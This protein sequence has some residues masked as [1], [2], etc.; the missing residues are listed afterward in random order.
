MNLPRKI[1]LLLL[2]LP[3]SVPVMFCFYFSVRQQIVRHQMLEAME[4]KE[5]QMIVVASDKVEW[6]EKGKELVIEGELFD[7]KEYRFEAGHIIAKGLSDKKETELKNSLERSMKEDGNE[8][9]GSKII[10]KL[11]TQLIWDHNYQQILA[12]SSMVIL[13]K[14]FP[15]HISDLTNSD[16][17][18]PY[19]PPKI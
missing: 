10:N 17:S 18:L 14:K 13:K 2:L 7:V 1:S 19:P 3:V 16:I 15:F 11:I 12:G 9:R 4:Q 8:A 6:F 5:L